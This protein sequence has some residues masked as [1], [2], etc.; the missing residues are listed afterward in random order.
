MKAAHDYEDTPWL[1][2]DAH[3]RSLAAT[4]Q[5]TNW[6]TPDQAIWSQY[7]SR[8]IKDLFKR[9]FERLRTAGQHQYACA[10]IERAAG[11]QTA[12]IDIS[13]CHAAM[14]PI[15]S[16]IA[17][18][19]HSPDALT[20]LIFGHWQQPSSPLIGTPRIK[21]SGRSTLAGRYQGEWAVE[22]Y[23]SGH[24]GTPDTRHDDSP[25]QKKYFQ[26]EVRAS[27]YSRTAP[28]CV[29]WNREGC[30]SP[31]CTYRH[32]C[33]SCRQTAL[34]QHSPDATTEYHF[35]IETSSHSLFRRM[36]DPPWAP[37]DS[38]STDKDSLHPLL[39]TQSSTSSSQISISHAPHSL[40]ENQPSR[41]PL[42]TSALTTSDHALLPI[43]IVTH[44]TT[45]QVNGDNEQCHALIVAT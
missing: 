38:T 1:S 8:T 2:Y 13:A 21:R 42:N 5:S 12:P 23:Q 45:L 32:I 15:E 25:R 9:R 3:F 31:D 44:Y 40:P 20:M 33:L 6:N 26:K 7:F 16:Q 22:L 14:A 19:Q 17:L 36:G 30:R 11:I 34:K 35:E 37:F 4:I 43:P 27:P 41:S 29:R 28:I 10:G 39:Q 24:T 18:K